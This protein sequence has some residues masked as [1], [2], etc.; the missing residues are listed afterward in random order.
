MQFRRNCRCAFGAARESGNVKCLTNQAPVVAT[1]ALLFVVT[2][3]IGITS[4]AEL[5]Y[6]TVTSAVSLHFAAPR[7]PPYALRLACL[8]LGPSPVQK[9][10]LDERR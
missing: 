4:I 10:P 5:G 1:V 8:V 6:K 2:P 9:M 3:L 7:A